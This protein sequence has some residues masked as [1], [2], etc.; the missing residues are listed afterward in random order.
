MG[1]VV[2]IVAVDVVMDVAVVVLV[3][4]VDRVV[5]VTTVLVEA[6]ADAVCRIRTSPPQMSWRIGD[7]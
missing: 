7:V 2:V 1:D 3:S 5:V 6:D 4:V